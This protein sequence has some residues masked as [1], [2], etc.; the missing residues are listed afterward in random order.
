MDF[1]VYN[2]FGEYFKGNLDSCLDSFNVVWVLKRR[3]SGFGRV[4]M[5]LFG[6]VVSVYVFYRR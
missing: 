5:W 3:L 2:C 6:V 1:E 4:F